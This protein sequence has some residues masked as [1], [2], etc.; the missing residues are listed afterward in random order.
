MTKS[1]MRKYLKDAEKAR[2]LAAQK[3]KEA[4]ES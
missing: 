3:L 4:E 2:E 1:Q